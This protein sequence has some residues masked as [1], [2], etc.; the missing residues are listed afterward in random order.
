MTHSGSAHSGDTQWRHTVEAG[1]A[2][3]ALDRDAVVVRDVVV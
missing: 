2:L 3:E 1:E